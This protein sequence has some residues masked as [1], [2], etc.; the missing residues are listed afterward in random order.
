MPAFVGPTCRLTGPLGQLKI[1]RAQTC[2]RPGFFSIWDP[3]IGWGHTGHQKEAEKDTERQTD[4]DR[5]IEI[6]RWRDT[7]RLWVERKK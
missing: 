4:G 7:C 5:D 3:S 2:T 1:N 6:D